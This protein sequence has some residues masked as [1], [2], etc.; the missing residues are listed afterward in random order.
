M[1][2]FFRVSG[3]HP[4]SNVFGF[5]SLLLRS[6]R[7]EGWL[8]G[9]PSVN[10]LLSESPFLYHPKEHH[11]VGFHRDPVAILDFGSLYPSLFMAHNLC[12]STLL[13]VEDVGKL[14]G[15]QVMTRWPI[16]FIFRFRFRF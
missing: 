11:S 16:T 13:H 8:L 5:Q 2:Y 1:K 4:C 3:S 6:G 9:G 14:P 7:R 10:G 12:Y 15:D